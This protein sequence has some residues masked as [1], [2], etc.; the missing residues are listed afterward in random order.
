MNCF[1]LEK[2]NH[3]LGKPK[4]SLHAGLAKQAHMRVIRNTSTLLVRIYFTLN[5]MFY[6]S[7]NS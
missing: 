5:P 1:L 7:S 2:L 6:A 3:L 4:I